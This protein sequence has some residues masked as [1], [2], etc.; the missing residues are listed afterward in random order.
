VSYA[1]SWL[2]ALTDEARALMTRRP[3]RIRRAALGYAVSH[4]VL[5][6]DQA[7]HLLGWRPRYSMPEAMAITRAWLVAT[8]QLPQRSPITTGRS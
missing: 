3:P 6:T 7:H 5:S 4:A 8:N 2:I 1:A